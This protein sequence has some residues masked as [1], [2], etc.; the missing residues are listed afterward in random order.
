MRPLTIGTR[1]SALALWQAHHVKARLEATEPGREVRLLVIKT[2]GDKILDAPLAKIGGKGLFVKEIEDALLDGRADLAVHSLKDVPA[3]LAP[4]LVLAA[5]SAREDPRDALVSREGGDLA[6]LPAGAVVGTSSLRRACLLRAQRPD[7]EV[8]M[9]RGNVDTRLRKLDAGE[10]DAVLLAAAGL[11]RLGRADRI[12]ERLDTG[13]FLPAIGQ[14]VLA[15]ET[16]SGD[17]ETIALVRRALGDEDT[18]ACVAAERAFLHRLGG[19]CQTPLACHA[20]LEGDAL[21][22]DGLV[23]EPDG[24]LIVRAQARGRREEGADV[25]RRLAEDL[26]ARGAAAILERLS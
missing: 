23:G 4:G 2:K 7:L 12:S 25:G 13:R 24:S 17:D 3:E 6:S 20:T 22:V 16:R 21:A 14:G 1:G 15:L 10:M 11:V 18:S 5:I 26:L 19:G 9:L 8:K